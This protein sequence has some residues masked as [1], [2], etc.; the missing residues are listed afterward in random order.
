MEVLRPLKSTH[1]QAHSLYIYLRKS[2]PRAIGR[3]VLELPSS[4]VPSPSESAVPACPISATSSRASSQT[5][6]P[7]RTCPTK[8]S[9]SR[10]RD[11]CH[12][13]LHRILTMSHTAA[14]DLKYG[15]ST[16]SMSYHLYH[17]QASIDSLRLEVMI[18]PFGTRRPKL[19]VQIVV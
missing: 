9:Q 5:S 8:N 10:T 17:G 16:R 11:R 3:E 1:L 12:F 14:S 15:R 18:E 7:G 19:Q 6:S 13:W 2:A 4:P